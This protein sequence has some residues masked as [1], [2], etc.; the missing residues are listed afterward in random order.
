ME[1]LDKVQVSTEQLKELVSQMSLDNTLDNLQNYHE[2][3]FEN[4]ESLE[5]EECFLSMNV[6]VTT[7]YKE[8][9][10]SSGITIEDV[11]I[12]DVELWINEDEEIELTDEMIMTLQN[13]ITNQ[14]KNLI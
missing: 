4:Y 5:Q 6:E 1:V 13:E 3:T 11:S 8:T 2:S 14:V 9:A 7:A 12:S 10:F